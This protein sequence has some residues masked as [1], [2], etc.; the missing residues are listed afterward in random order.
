ML[1]EIAGSLEGTDLGLEAE[2]KKM[3]SSTRASSRMRNAHTTAIEP[4]DDRERAIR[5]AERR[6]RPAAYRFT[7]RG[8]KIDVLP[9][10]TSLED[11]SFARDTFEELVA[12]ARD[13][14]RRLRGSNSAQRACLSIERLLETLNDFDNMRAGVLLS[15]VRSIEADLF[16]FDSDDGRDEMISPTAL[17]MVNDTLQ[18]AR[19][20]MSLFPMVRRVETE[21]LALDLDRHVEALP[22][23]QRD[24]QTL[25]EAAT[26]SEALT[27]PARD[28]LRQNDTAIADAVDPVLRTSLIADKLLVVRNFTGAVGSKIGIE[29]GALGLRSWEAFKE[30]LPQGIG[31]AARFGPLLLLGT[32]IAGPVAG[33]A[34]VL[35][36]FKSVAR[37]LNKMIPDGSRNDRGTPEHQPRDIRSRKTPLAYGPVTRNEGMVRKS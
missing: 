8:D 12:K 37:L 19:D 25:S 18:T 14:L 21:R 32:L 10:P 24:M 6:Q 9:E 1:G 22:A 28:A 20:L 17:A 13:T 4:G 33:I 15:R 29:L 11:P 3:R 7:I 27:G 31:V 26:G 34:M 36:A 23:I 16:A 2:V 35:P 30:S 5:A